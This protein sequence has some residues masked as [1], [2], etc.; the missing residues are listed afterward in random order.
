MI[1]LLSAHELTDTDLQ[2]LVKIC[3]E[4]YDDLDAEEALRGLISG[5]VLMFRLLEPVEGLLMITETMRTGQKEWFIN[6]F[7][8]KGVFSKIFLIVKGL[9]V[10]AKE[11]G[12]K[13][14]TGLPHR[15]G[16]FQIYETL[17]AKKKAVLYGLEV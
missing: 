5:N 8:G 12:V 15:P 16:L 4:S 6:G 9:K 14:I 11:R 13:E 7:A 3:A 10:F 1:K 2:W 17:G